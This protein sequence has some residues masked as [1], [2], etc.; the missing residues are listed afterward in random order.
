M[1]G[2]VTVYFFD[3]HHSSIYPVCVFHKLTGLECPGCGTLRGTYE[4]LHGHFIAAFHDNALFML[5]LPFLMWLAGRY[6]F[7]LARGRST[8]AIIIRPS[9]LWIWLGVMIVFTVLRNFSA[10]SWLSP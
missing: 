1:A 8:A 6:L 7:R 9:W 4:L 10:F 5:T 3:P 2:L